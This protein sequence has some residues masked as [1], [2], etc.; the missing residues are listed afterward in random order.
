KPGS[1]QLYRRPIRDQQQRRR[2]T[3]ARAVALKPSVSP[4][5]ESDDDYDARLAEFMALDEEEQERRL[6]ELAKGLP[7][8]VRQLPP[9]LS[10]LYG[11]ITDRASCRQVLSPTTPPYMFE[12]YEAFDAMIGG[13]GLVIE[14]RDPPLDRKL[15]IKLWKQ[16][17]PE[18]QRALL[19][20]AQTLAKLSHRNVV[21][22]YGTGRCNLEHLV[23][24]DPSAAGTMGDR[25]FFMMEWIDG[26]DGRVWLNTPRTWREVRNV[27]VQA[28]RGLA[29]AHDAG[30]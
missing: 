10:E 25:V 30:I 18:A 23:Q 26:V 19:K 11:L 6:E 21:T 28:G 7:Q 3:R 2:R 16:S 1:R 29:A 22:V 14:A 24:D 15:A 13:M 12:G 8:P 27:F 9:D 4:P 17:G 5:N 20:E